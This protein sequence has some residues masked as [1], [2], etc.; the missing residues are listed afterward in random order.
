MTRLT[1]P[2]WIDNATVGRFRRR[3]RP[4][5]RPGGTHLAAPGGT[6]GESEKTS[7]VQARQAR[8][9]R[10]WQLTAAALAVAALV[11]GLGWGIAAAR[12]PQPVLVHATQPSDLEGL[13]PE[14]DANDA[15]KRAKV[16]TARDVKRATAAATVECA[17]EAM[18]RKHPRTGYPQMIEVGIDFGTAKRSGDLAAVAHAG[19][20]HEE[21]MENVRDCARG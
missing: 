12:E 18:M 4:G 6:P 10:A 17:V 19:I 14:A 21:L 16:T 13:I 9:V 3:P 5:E 1:R 20:E 7:R 2:A 15:I 8:T 11:F